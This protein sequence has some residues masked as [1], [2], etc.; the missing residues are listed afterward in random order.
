MAK[1]TARTSVGDQPDSMKEDGDEW[2]KCSQAARNLN[3][4]MQR[5]HQLITQGKLRFKWTPYGR[6]VSLQS[7]E[8]YDVARRD[9]LYSDIQHE[10]AK[11]RMKANPNS[12]GRGGELKEG[13]YEEIVQEARAK[14]MLPPEKMKEAG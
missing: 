9:F 7:V 3:V 14:G 13:E 1:N 8:E 4:S 12:Y 6:I 10:M 11:E 2:V 5:I